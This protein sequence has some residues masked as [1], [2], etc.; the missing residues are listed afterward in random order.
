[1]RITLN[2]QE[3]VIPG[4]QLTIRD[5]LK[6]KNFSFPNLV[7]RINGKLVK[8]PD[9]DTAIAKEGDFVEIIHLISGG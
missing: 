6:F 5:I 7:V 2:R 3:E 1:M 8:K 9:Y 4:D